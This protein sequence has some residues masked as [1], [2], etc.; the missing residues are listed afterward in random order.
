MLAA[1]LQCDSTE[2]LLI[3]DLEHEADLLCLAAAA[4]LV[5]PDI[6]VS[7]INNI[8]IAGDQDRDTRV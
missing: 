1:A 6:D 8:I 2:F 3:V 7:V 4:V 5:F